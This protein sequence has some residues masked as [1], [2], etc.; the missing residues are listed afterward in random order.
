MMARGVTIVGLGPGD[1]HLVTHEAR[2]VLETAPEIWLRTMQHPAAAF[3]AVSKRVSSFDYLAHKRGPL[4]RVHQVLAETVLKLGRRPEGV[5]YAVPGHPLIDDSSVKMILRLVAE[6]G[7][8]VA[9]V[10]GISFVDQS[11]A[12]LGPEATSSGM[13]VVDGLALADFA[14]RRKLA[15]AP[16]DDREAFLQAT[17]G[18]P[19]ESVFPL[20]I[21]PVQDR[22]TARGVEALLLECYPP[23]HPVMLLGHGENGSTPKQ[24][25]LQYLVRQFS[26][27]LSFSFFSVYVPPLPRE[28]APAS[29]SGLRYLVARLRGPGGCPWDREQTHQSLKPY[30]VEEAYETL[31]AL[32]SGDTKKFVEELGDLLLQVVLHAQL[33]SEE[34]AFRLEEVFRAVGGKLIRRHPHVFGDINVSGAE[35]VLRN[36][37]QWKRNEEGAVP[38]L[39]GGLPRGMPALAYAQSAQERARRVGLEV[40]NGFSD[41]PQV[42]QRVQGIAALE[43][44]DER[45]R[46]AG[47]ALFDL[48][49]ILRRA[50]VDAEEALRVSSR[51]FVSRFRRLE[52]LCAEEGAELRALTP[53]QVAVYWAGTDDR[54]VPNPDMKEGS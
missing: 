13:Q 16:Q 19:F 41:L 5:V 31:E 8:P 22:Q 34:G 28:A 1:W 14:A 2:K 46:M 27:G 7:L 30:I 9:V 29:M 33:A 42:V 54:N 38:S 52:E 3:L 35:E 11:L 32:D 37:E 25:P 50:G 17:S 12:Q 44:T 10:A 4:A 23:E 49:A 26:H 15:E 39:L 20:L 48:V 24:V 45:L 53:E 51:R 21:S 6:E 43:D 40:G 18:P 36:W 47:E